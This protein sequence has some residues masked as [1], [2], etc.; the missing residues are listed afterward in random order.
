MRLI[1]RLV[2]VGAVVA[3]VAALAAPSVLAADHG[4]S[5]HGFAFDPATITVAVGDSVTWTNGDPTAHTA[6]GDGGAFD[7]GTV[8][9]GASKT[10]VFSIAGTY[11]YHCAIHPSMTATVVVGKAP[12]TQAPTDTVVPSD[13]PPDDSAILAVLAA[14]GA[15]MLV[16]TVLADRRLRGRP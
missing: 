6:T 16:G 13:G 2:G 1:G 4:V 10:V 15:S 8:A 3:L 7:A 9:A 14:L 5:I 12:M 11:P